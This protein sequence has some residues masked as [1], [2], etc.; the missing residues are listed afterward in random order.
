MNSISV[1][2]PAVPLTNIVEN[3]FMRIPKTSNIDFT[4]KKINVN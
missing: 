3:K 2:K 4:L 1:D